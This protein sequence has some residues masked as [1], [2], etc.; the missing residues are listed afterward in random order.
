LHYSGHLLGSGRLPNAKIESRANANFLNQFKLIWPVQSPAKKYF[1]FAV[2]QIKNISP[3]LVPMEGRLAIVKD[4]GR[5][6]VDAVAS[7]T[8][9]CVR[10]NGAFADG[11][12][13][14]S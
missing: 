10:T 1:A 12:I 6:A 13:V 7:G 2:G 3:R 11:E 14:W 5:D 9:S 8:Q 4:A